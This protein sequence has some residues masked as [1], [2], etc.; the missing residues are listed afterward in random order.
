MLDE[1]YESSVWDVRQPMLDETY[2]SQWEEF[3]PDEGEDPQE[4]EPPAGF[5]TWV[6]SESGQW[7]LRLANY[8]MDPDTTVGVS[9][10]QA[11]WR[12]YSLRKKMVGV[13]TVGYLRLLMNQKAGVK[14][15]R[16]QRDIWN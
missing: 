7:V 10:I 14:R 2:E 13:Y 8:D 4:P 15:K 16:W 5:M 11:L 9:G 3:H 1:T 6:R 12:G